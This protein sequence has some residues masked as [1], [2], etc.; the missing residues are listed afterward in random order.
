MIFHDQNGGSGCDSHTFLPISSSLLIMMIQRR[1]RRG[2][3]TGDRRRRPPRPV[4]ELRGGEACG[5]VPGRTKRLVIE[6]PWLV[7]GG[8]GA[9]LSL[10]EGTWKEAPVISAEDETARNVGESQSRLRVIVGAV[11]GR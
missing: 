11:G 7:D 8:H 2:N 6:A 10:R 3:L 1:K 5:R 4:R 9:S